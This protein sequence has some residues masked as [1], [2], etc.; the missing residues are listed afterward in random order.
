MARVDEDALAKALATNS[1]GGAALDVFD[2]GPVR[3][4]HRLLSLPNVI[5]TP[6]IGFVTERSYRIF[7]RETA[8]N[9]LAWLDEL[10]L[11]PFRATEPSNMKSGIFLKPLDQNNGPPVRTISRT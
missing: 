6:H 8:E 11:E 4:G 5:A 10:R 7:Y 1:I 3:L 9:L 2:D